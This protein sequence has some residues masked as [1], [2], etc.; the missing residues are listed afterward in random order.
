MASVH[1]DPQPSESNQNSG[2]RNQ[3]ILPGHGPQRA[4][5]ARDRSQ[6]STQS[7]YSERKK[8]T[9]VKKTG[10]HGRLQSFPKE[11]CPR[12]GKLFGNAWHESPSTK[13]SIL[14]T[15]QRCEQLIWT[16]DS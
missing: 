14:Q 16:A 1:L 10:L 9:D 6:T 2:E 15:V 4:P 12:R 5:I 3:V 8:K 7:K 13:E 11:H